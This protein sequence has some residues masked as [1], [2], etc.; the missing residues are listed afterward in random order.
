MDPSAEELQSITNVAGLL[1]WVG[2]EDIPLVLE[3]DGDRKVIVECLLIIFNIAP[4][5]EDD[6][7]LDWLLTA[8]RTYAHLKRTHPFGGF[9]SRWFFNLARFTNHIQGP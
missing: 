6:F 8:F 7:K 2:L 9:R 1:D 3:A 5:S 4:A